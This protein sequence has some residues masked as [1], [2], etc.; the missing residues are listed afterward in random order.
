MMETTLAFVIFWGVWILIP[1]IIDGI[2]TI[3]RLAVVFLARRR[4][5]VVELIEELLPTVTII[6]PAYNEAQI[7]DRCLNSLKVQ[8]YPHDKME[9]I[10]VD[11]G[12]TDGTQALV[13]NHVN[14]NGKNGHNGNGNGNGVRINGKF[15]P[16]GDFSGVVKLVSRQHKGKAN[17]L[18]TG[19]T[20]AHGDIIVNI[21]SDIVLAPHALRRMIEAFVKD[22][23]LGAATGNIE[24]NAEIIDERDEHGHLVLDEEDNPI[25][26][27][28]TSPEKF[29]AVSQFL[30]YLNAFRLGREAQ[31]RS[32]TLYT[33]SGAFSAFRREIILKSSLY[34]A[35]TV[36]ED[37]DLTLDI[38]RQNVR[39]GYVAEAKA[40]L[41][42][43]IEWD[44]L[45]SQ[46]VRWNRGQLEV[47]GVHQDMCGNG[48]FGRLG[49]FGLPKML[50]VDHTLAFPR[51]IWT[52]L[53]PFFI[54]F[55]YSI[56]IISMA[57]V[58]MYLF[59][60][61]L[62]FLNTIA[63]YY[64]VD[65]DT[66][67]LINRDLPY[68]LLL[69]IYRFAV[70]HFRMSGYLIV[71][72]EPPSWTVPG[73][74][75]GIK[76]GVNDLSKSLNGATGFLSF[77]L[78]TISVTLTAAVA[79]IAGTFAVVL[80]PRPSLSFFDAI[81]RL[82]SAVSTPFTSIIGGLAGVIQGVIHVFVVMFAYLFMFAGFIRGLPRLAVNAVVH[83]T[84]VSF[85][86]MV[87]AYDPDMIEKLGRKLAMIMSRVLS[88]VGF[89]INIFSKV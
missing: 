23:M 75:N 51:L 74:V 35:V 8:D 65:K 41:E 89:F 52:L 17:A 68:C 18:N 58:A 82:F 67:K 87:L 66:R 76:N 1:I 7:I 22:P 29:L 47:C 78:R 54:F 53:L 20:H 4:R 13:Q 48:T 43:V 56:R 30:E 9:V 31:S 15:I 26:K 37:T 46:R 61:L 70:F 71:L 62:D 3:Y 19:I 44:K 6:V 36:S 88:I 38:H 77:V 64:L 84:L 73:P 63:V 12:S 14:G 86:F 21:D 11:D 72:K 57:I 55:G 69:P 10:V 85:G 33:L 50:T 80:L 16:V 2:E 28:L 81:Q 34:R 59:Y 49:L 32:N 60:V 24:I 79:Q 83:L 39:I 25:P 45:Y 27:R 5:T 42:P 40:Y